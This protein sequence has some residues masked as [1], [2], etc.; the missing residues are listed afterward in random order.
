MK[1]YPLILI[2]NYNFPKMKKQFLLLLIFTATISFAQNNKQN[3]RG[4]IID[5]LSQVPIPGAIV[6]IVNDSLNK[7]VQTDVNGNYLIT[8]VSPKRYT[9]KASFVGYKDIFIP[10]V[11]VSSGKETILDITMEEDLKMLN[12]V[13][14]KSNDKDKTD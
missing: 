8:D 13:I 12:E 9:V 7:A 14:V 1:S 2:L 4:E 3:I 10:N 5:K 11:V 6:I